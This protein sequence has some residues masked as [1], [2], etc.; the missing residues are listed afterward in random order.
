MKKNTLIAQLKVENALLK[1][2]LVKY[3]VE[4]KLQKLMVEVREMTNLA[5]LQMHA[6]KTLQ[7]A[8]DKENLNG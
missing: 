3:E 8:I 2:R 6:G 1:Q 4:E 5:I 7:S